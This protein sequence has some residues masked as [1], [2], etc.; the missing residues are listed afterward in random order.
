M[1]LSACVLYLEE[2]EKTLSVALGHASW[3]VALLKRKKHISSIFCPR[4]TLGSEHDLLW[5]RLVIYVSSDGNINLLKASGIRNSLYG[6]FPCF[7]GLLTEERSKKHLKRQEDKRYEII[8]YF[9]L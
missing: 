4:L 9:L 7:I 5:T 8:K 3:T 1:F 6:I 2:G